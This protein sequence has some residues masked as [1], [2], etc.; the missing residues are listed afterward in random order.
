LY[1]MRRGSQNRAAS[2]N[3]DLGLPEISSIKISCNEL[4]ITKF[5]APK[6]DRFGLGTTPDSY[7]YPLEIEPSRLRRWPRARK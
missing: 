5:V 2:P 6:K 1:Q 3:Q 4:C 7:F